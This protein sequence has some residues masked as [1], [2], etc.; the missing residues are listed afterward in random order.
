MDGV[1]QATLEKVMGNLPIMLRSKACNL[2]DMNPAQLVEKGEQETEWGGYFVIGG[3]ERLVRMLQTT[4]RNYPIAMSRPS[5]KKRGKNFSDLGI[6]LES[7]KTDLTTCRNVLHFVSTGTAKYMF[8]YGKELFF[9]PV[10]LILK[11]LTSRSDK[12]I[13]EELTAGTDKEDHYYINCLKSMLYE[14]HSEGLYSSEQVREYMGKSFRDRLKNV[15][16]EWST[17]LEVCDFL[18]EEQVCIHLKDKEDK[19]QMIVFMI[20]KL[21]ALV[22]SFQVLAENL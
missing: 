3:H 20:K 15:L 9:V 10:I 14:P 13:F 6:M 11:C 4:R 8:N 5:W 19:F 16:P 18:M 2:S 7:G 21:F 17:N 22:S 1:V 12:A